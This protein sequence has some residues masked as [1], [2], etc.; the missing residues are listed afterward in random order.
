MVVLTRGSFQLYSPD[1]YYYHR[2]HSTTTTAPPNTATTG[3]Q[4][5]IRAW[6]GNI[7]PSP[8]VFLCFCVLVCASP[9][10]LVCSCRHVLLLFSAKYSN[11]SLQM[12]MVPLFSDFLPQ[13]ES[14]ERA[15]GGVRAPKRM[16]FRDPPPF[17]F[18]EIFSGWQKLQG[19]TGGTRRKVWTRT[20]ILSP[21]IRYFV[22]N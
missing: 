10:V 13:I 2:Y 9:Q 21:N 8:Q 18:S 17:S 7:C 14:S 16:N 5:E 20:K 4:T 22:A 3:P 12:Q 6:T 15:K 11:S 1:Y 19:S